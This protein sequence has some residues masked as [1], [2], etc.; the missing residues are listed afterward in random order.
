MTFKSGFAA[1]IGRTNV[2]KS[3]LLNALLEEKVAITSDKPQTTRNT[4]QGILTGEDY[5]VVFIDTPGIHKPKH[6]LSEIMIESVKKTLTEVDLIIYMVEPDAEVG[7][8][9]KYIIEHL[10][11][12]DT[13]VI[14]VINK[15]DTVPHE[16][17]D[18]TIE[19]F[20]AQYNFK[21]ILPISALKNKNIDLLKHTIV[22][23]MPEGPQYFP[24]DYIT[25]RPEKFLVSE[26]IR[27]KILNYL[28]DEVPHGV[29]VEV[30]SMKVRENK[31]ILDIE[32]FI[33]CEKESHK[34][35]IIGKNGQMLRKIGSSA[36]TELESLFGQK[37]Y[38][39]L[40]VKVKKGWRDNISILRNFGYVIDKS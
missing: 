3:T 17:V 25:D 4:I 15:I 28:E 1:L 30:N 14:L 5:Q 37:I 31:D 38:L 40:W 2:G 23:Y 33:F 20:K 21:D 32:A 24:S 27:E 6:K 35:I 29:Y 39:D 16:T 8:G 9:D 11:S 22:S 12:I 19:N 10:I 13:P 26:I 7:P 34:A 36:R 18:K